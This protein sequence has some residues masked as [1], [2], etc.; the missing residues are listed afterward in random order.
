MVSVCIATYNGERFIRRQIESILPQLDSD[1]EIIVSDDGSTDNTLDIIRGFEE[2]RICIIDGA[3]KGSPIWNFE[4]ALSYAHG[5]YVFLCDQDDEWMP[6]K[7]STMLKALRDSYCVV[8]DCEVIYTTSDDVVV[9]RKPSFFSF[10]HTRSG[11]IYNLMVKNGY[12]GCCMAFRRAVL[13]KALPFPKECPMHDIW[14]GNVAAF[15]YSVSFVHDKLIRFHRHASNAS[16]TGR[17]SGNG[18][19]GK[20]K[21]R[22]D[23]IKELAKRK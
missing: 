3:H 10:N 11:S 22:Y 1:D 19:L 2:S 9:E 7:V 16:T 5:D 14:I 20:L 15:Y 18:L 17:P 13:D 23:V 6:N 21:V 4:K 12:L 8:S